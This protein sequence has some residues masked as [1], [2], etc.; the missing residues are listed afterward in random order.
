MNAIKPKLH[1]LIGI[2]NLDRSG[3]EYLLDKAEYFLQANYSDLIKMPPLAGKI[4]A[5][6]FFEPSTRTQNSFVLAAKKLGA[7]VLNPELSNSSIKKGETLLDT[8]R[9]FEAMGVSIFIIR[10]SENNFFEFITPKLNPKTH[11]INAGEG[12]HRHPTQALLDVLTIRQH[13]KKFDNLRVAIIGDILHSRVAH[14]CM[15][16]FS[17]M[18]VQEI[19]L[20]APPQF[21]PEKIDLPIV[22]IYHSLKDGLRDAD[23][24]MALR[25]Q[26]ERIQKTEFP[27]LTRFVAEY[28]LNRENIKAAKPDA[29]IM[30][31]G[32][33][34]RGIEIDSDLADG[35]QSVILQQIE[36][37]VAM[38]MA[39]LDL[40]AQN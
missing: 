16:A 17:I 26:N 28:G 35:P 3:M 5:T 9:S 23:V 20:I 4:V 6:L 29:I 40:L 18:G 21:L 2:E 24:V 25:I 15:R 33:V 8:I 19:R 12:S 34:N 27:D 13:K 36:N 10:H 30:H 7:L 14:S 11:L 38:R 32:P 31:P 37:G 22:K 39:I 1:H